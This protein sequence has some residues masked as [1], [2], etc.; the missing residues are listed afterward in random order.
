MFDTTGM[1]LVSLG[2]GGGHNGYLNGQK[3]D[4]F[5]GTVIRFVAL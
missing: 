3:F 1:L 5:L 2:D 4:N